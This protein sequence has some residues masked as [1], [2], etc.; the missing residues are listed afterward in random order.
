[1]SCPN[2]KFDTENMFPS[3]CSCAQQNIEVEDNTKLRMGNNT[4][5]PRIKDRD[6]NDFQIANNDYYKFERISGSSK[7]QMKYFPSTASDKERTVSSKIFDNI[8]YTSPTQ[9]KKRDKT[10]SGETNDFKNK[11]KDLNKENNK[12]EGFA[13][14]FTSSTSEQ[15]GAWQSFTKL[16]KQSFKSSTNDKDNNKDQNKESFCGFSSRPM[17]MNKTQVTSYCCVVAVIVLII[18]IGII[19]FCNKPC[20]NTDDDYCYLLTSPNTKANEYLSMG[21][22]CP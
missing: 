10:T 17:N 18:V 19:L 3:P 22:I 14:L 11:P 1:M 15:G 9:W 13:N 8:G 6:I 20:C 2:I 5:F 21:M 7:N 4:G 16:L 12:K